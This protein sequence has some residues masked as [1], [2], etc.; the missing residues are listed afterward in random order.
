[1]YEAY[2]QQ[3]PN[4]KAPMKRDAIF[5]IYSMTK[6]LTSV[7][8]MMLVEEGRMKLSD[9]VSMYLPEL[10][11]LKVATNAATAKDAAGI[12]T[13]PA[14]RPIRVLDLLMHTSGLTYGFFKGVPGGSALEQMYLDGGENDLDITN[15]ELVTRLSK[16]PLKYEPGTTWWY[17]R[18]SDVLGR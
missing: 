12:E 16:L 13:K 4:T 10:A 8:A 9:P 3:D 14:T 1:Y 18:S 17:S 5:R 11:N 6:P 7:A 15:A 2:G